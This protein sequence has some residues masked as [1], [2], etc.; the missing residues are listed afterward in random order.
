MDIE[1]VVED[2]MLLV[3]MSKLTRSEKIKVGVLIRRTRQALAGVDVTDLKKGF[4]IAALYN[5][6]ISLYNNTASQTEFDC[7]VS[8]LSNLLER[9][10]TDAPV[11]DHPPRHCHGPS[12]GV[13]DRDR[14]V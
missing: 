1:S 8:F 12:A 6:V 2:C 11:H 3:Q 5:E 14:P 4:L 10:K 7:S 9:Q 13:D